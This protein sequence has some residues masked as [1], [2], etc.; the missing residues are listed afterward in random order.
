MSKGKKGSGPPLTSGSAQPLEIS[1]DNVSDTLA[2][3]DEFLTDEAPDLRDVLASTS[4]DGL[5]NPYASGQGGWSFGAQDAASGNDQGS[6]NTNPFTGGQTI[7]PFTGVQ[8]ANVFSE[9][10]YPAS[11]GGATDPSPAPMPGSPPANAN[12]TPDVLVPVSTDPVTQAAIDQ[13][14]AKALTQLWSQF[15]TQGAPANAPQADPVTYYWQGVVYD[16]NGNAYNK[17]LSSLGD[18]SYYPYNSEAPSIHAFA[19]LD[20]STSQPAPPPNTPVPPQAQTSPVSPAPASPS[21]PFATPLSNSDNVTPSRPQP[22]G[23]GPTGAGPGVSPGISNEQQD[24]DNWSAAKSGMWDSAVDMVASLLNLGNPMAGPLPAE[25]ASSLSF[26]PRI[27]LDWA[28][29]GPPAQTGD[30]ARD[31]ALRDNYRRGGWV[32]ATI[33]LASPFAL[34]GLPASAALANSRLGALAGAG[35]EPALLGS[36]NQAGGGERALAQ[37]KILIVGAESDLEFANASELSARGNSVTVV[38]PLETEPASAYQA[39]GGD[40][41]PI[42]VEDVPEKFDYVHE[43]Y[44]QPILPGTS[45]GL[46]AAAARLNTLEPGGVLTTITENRD[47]ADTYRIAAE[48]AGMSFSQSEVVTNLPESPWVDPG[49]PRFFILIRNGL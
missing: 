43:N 8:D 32:A 45:V 49:E 37:S 26:D 9:A 35:A 25:I 29:S 5:S 17:F 14:D 4:L 16:E 38:N 13:D 7:N 39:R 40:F 18:T 42:N 31:A 10:P 20:I 27:S 34:E 15:T 24:E 6:A 3:S 2:F 36:L 23:A 30:A 48:R 41:R 21:D 28:K 1:G 11:D 22:V 19:P 12:L 33:S 46:D 44:P 47:L